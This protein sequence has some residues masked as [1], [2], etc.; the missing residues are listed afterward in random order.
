VLI[1]DDNDDMRDFIRQTVSPCYRTAEASDGEDGLKKARQVMPDIIISDVMMPKMDGYALCREIR[2]SDTLKNIPV[3][4]VTARASDEMTIDG[5][6]AG[7]YDYITKPF[8]PKILLAKIDSI[9]ERQEQHKKQ[10]QHDS[11]TGLLNREIWTKRVLQEMEKNR[12]HGNIFSI[13]F[14]D[15]DNFKKINDT[16][17]HQAGDEVLKTFSTV[18]T[19]NLRAYDLAGR[20]GGEEFVIFFPETTGRDAADSLERIMQLFSEQKIEGKALR[21]TF[22]AGVIEMNP[23]MDL[24]LEEYLSM[25]DETMYAAKKSGKARIFLYGERIKNPALMG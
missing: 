8:S 21:C 23:L 4:L 20:L 2:N 6:E 5:L 12:R 9:L 25:A 15:L 1:I 16:Y 7:A 17:S 19:D 18:I 11:L 3:I 22:S 10:T 14:L 24:T 13:A